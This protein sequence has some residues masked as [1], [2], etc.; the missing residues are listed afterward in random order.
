VPESELLDALASGFKYV[1]GRVCITGADKLS[2]TSKSRSKSRLD[3]GALEG[4]GFTGLTI[5]TSESDESESEE[6]D[7]DESDPD[8]EGDGD[9]RMIF[10]CEMFT[11][12]FPH[13]DS[14]SDSDSESESESEAEVEE[15]EDDSESDSE[16]ELP[17]ELSSSDD[18]SE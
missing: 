14:D 17:E 18:V 6:T 12:S 4:A 11:E 16:S 2:E 3:F 7:W 1:H 15:E 9:R 8:G 10:C 13:S 5:S